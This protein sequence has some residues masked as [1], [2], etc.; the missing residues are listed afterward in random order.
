V[1]VYGGFSKNKA[2]FYN[3]LSAL[4]AV[5]GTVIGYALANMSDAFLKLLMPVA[6]GGFIYIACCDLVPELHKERDIKKAT[7]SMGVFILGV[8]FMCF[9]ATMHH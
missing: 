7:L 5:V 6:A 8:A 1:L 3:F 9:A 4:T 2:L